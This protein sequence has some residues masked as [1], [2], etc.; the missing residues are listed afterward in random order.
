V[1][2]NV[3]LIVFALALI[4]FGTATYVK[5]RAVA[6]AQENITQVQVDDTMLVMFAGPVGIIQSVLDEIAVYKSMK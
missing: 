2:K 1:V 4:L 6:I 5:D 3:S